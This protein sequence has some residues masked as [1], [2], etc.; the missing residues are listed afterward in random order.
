MYVPLSSYYTEAPFG[1]IPILSV[2]GV[3]VCG[4]INIARFVAERHGE[5]VDDTYVSEIYYYVK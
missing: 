2:D 1:H 3:E 5:C 4:S